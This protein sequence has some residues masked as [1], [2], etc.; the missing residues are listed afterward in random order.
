MLEC[1]GRLER[2]THASSVALH[3]QAGDTVTSSVMP[4][5]H[6]F[7]GVAAESDFVGSGYWDGLKEGS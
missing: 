2:S 7:G 6:A 4:H 3:L 1:H 5:T